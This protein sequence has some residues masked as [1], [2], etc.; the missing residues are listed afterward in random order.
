MEVGGGGGVVGGARGG[1]GGGEG[2]EEVVD[3]GGGGGRVAAG[4]GKRG[5]DDGLKV[6]GDGHKVEVAVGGVMVPEEVVAAGCCQRAEALV[7]MRGQ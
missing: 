7:E 2:E 1:A 4:G 3:V 6:S 5:S